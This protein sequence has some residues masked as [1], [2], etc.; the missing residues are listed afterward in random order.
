VS[1]GFLFWVF[2]G[3][4]P[5]W[6]SSYVGS[7]HLLFKLFALWFWMRIA[8]LGVPSSGLG[9]SMDNPVFSSAI[10]SMLSCLG[11]FC[12][13]KDQKEEILQLQHLCSDPCR[14][15][16]GTK[17]RQRTL[18]KKG[19]ETQLMV[20]GQAHAPFYEVLIVVCCTE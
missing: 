4:A 7:L 5:K 11:R 15:S 12:A 13:R 9:R 2:L 19:N 1:F 20:I 17:M 10:C 18:R 8:C 16:A 14:I 6:A 3:L